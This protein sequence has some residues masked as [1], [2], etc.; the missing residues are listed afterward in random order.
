MKKIKLSLGLYAIVDDE[1]FKKL[2]KYKWYSN[3]CGG[4][5]NKIYASKYIKLPNGKKGILRM[6]RFIMGVPTDKI[7][8][9]INKN[10]LD[11]RKINLRLCTTSQNKWNIGK[12]SNNKSGYKGVVFNN[13]RHKTKK[14]SAKIM[15]NG[16]SIWLGDYTTAK[17][18]ALKY[19]YAAEEYHKTFMSL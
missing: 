13:K 11:N 7:V 3:I 15:I 8:D 17:A 4:S 10:T 1:D 19:K 14:Y 16:K 18:A 9:H 6:H 5:K 2:N 12:Y